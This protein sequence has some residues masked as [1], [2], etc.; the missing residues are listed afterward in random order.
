MSIR[1]EMDAIMQERAKAFG[2]KE[3]KVT[4]TVNQLVALKLVIE[5]VREVHQVSEEDLEEEYELH[6]RT[7]YEAIDE[8]L[9]GAGT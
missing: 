1:E 6:L 8:A 5:E 9:D 7:S 2:R 4:L 3:I